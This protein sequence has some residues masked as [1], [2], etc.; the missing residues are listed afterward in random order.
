MPRVYRRKTDRPHKSGRYTPE[1]AD[2]RFSEDKNYPKR[3][4]ITVD[5]GMILQQLEDESQ[6]LINWAIYREKGVFSG[7]TY[8]FW[9]KQRVTQ[10]DYRMGDQCDPDVV[11]QALTEK[12]NRVLQQVGLPL[13]DKL[14]QGVKA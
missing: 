1:I 7:E 6:L 5:S 9:N 14:L 10:L 4:P 11:R 2:P 13:V 3:P 8:V 12:V